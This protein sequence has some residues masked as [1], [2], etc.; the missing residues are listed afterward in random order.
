MFSPNLL[1][2]PRNICLLVSKDK[3]VGYGS[4]S[5]C[6]GLNALFL[7]ECFILE[8]FGGACIPQMWVVHNPLELPFELD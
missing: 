4:V 6:I 8:C 3:H 1:Q 7:E 2:E 5:L